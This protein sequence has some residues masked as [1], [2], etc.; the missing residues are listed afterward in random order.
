M[1]IR[2]LLLLGAAC[3]AAL[4]AA[5]QTVTGPRGGT[6]TVERGIETVTRTGPYGGTVSYGRP[7]RT[8]TATGPN[9]GSATATTTCGRWGR[10]CA[11]EWSAT[12]PEGATAS[13]AG[14]LR[15]T[16]YGGT[17]ATRRV[18]GPAGVT[19]VRRWRW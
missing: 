10:T 16:P 11:R 1:R 5:A 14:V 17:V 13:G 6:A 9:G 12:G 18:T 8:T 3:L 19:G 2:G 7:T 15:R 4:P